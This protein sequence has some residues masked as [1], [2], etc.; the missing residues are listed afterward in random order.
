MHNPTPFLEGMCR[1]T[2]AKLVVFHF[3]H[4]T[5]IVAHSNVNFGQYIIMQMPFSN[6]PFSKV[7]TTSTFPQGGVGV[8]GSAHILRVGA[9]HATTASKAPIPASSALQ[10]NT[11]AQALPLVVP[12]RLQRIG[13][14]QNTVSRV[15]FLKRVGSSQIWLFQTWLFA[16]F[17]QKR[18][19]AL[20]CTLLRSFALFC[21]L[22]YALICALLRTFACFCVRP[23]LER[24]RLGTIER[25]RKKK[26]SLSSATNSVSSAKKSSVSWLLHTKNRLKGTC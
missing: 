24:P 2:C 3:G 13:N 17:T 19:F 6:A 16:I 11:G 8:L 15:L 20:F 14:G 9:S 23:R 22:L 7:P 1:Q 5:K 26:K 25:E 12:A 10:P 21:A 4:H 18:S